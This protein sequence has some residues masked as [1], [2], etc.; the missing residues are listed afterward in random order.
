VPPWAIRSTPLGTE[1]S[2]AQARREFNFQLSF[3]NTVT[4]IM[5]KRKAGET[6]FVHD[7][8]QPKTKVQNKK[9][10]TQNELFN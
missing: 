10:K 1:V 4:R 9:N 8:D 7:L 5:A 3:L 2:G 6:E